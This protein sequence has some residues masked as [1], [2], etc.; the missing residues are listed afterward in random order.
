[1]RHG[2]SMKIQS[3][4]QQFGLSSVQ[5]EKEQSGNSYQLKN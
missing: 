5:Q 1:M 2:E 3:C 4:A